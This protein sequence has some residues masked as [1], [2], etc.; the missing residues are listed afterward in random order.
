LMVEMKG[1][2]EWRECAGRAGRRL[3][4]VTQDLTKNGPVTK[5]VYTSFRKIRDVSDLPMAWMKPTRIP[6]GLAN[7]PLSLEIAVIIYVWYVRKVL[8]AETRAG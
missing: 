8:K 1:G 3:T 7:Y 4:N 6:C 2:H 5:S